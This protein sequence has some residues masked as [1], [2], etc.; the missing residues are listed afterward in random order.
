MAKRRI[1]MLLVLAMLLVMMA[2]QV[3]MGAGDE[4][5]IP[6]VFRKLLD[7]QIFDGQPVV[8]WSGSG[9]GELETV[10]DTLPI[11]TEVIYKGKPTL[12]LNLKEDLQSGWWIS[13]VTVRG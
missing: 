11:D 1:S 10:N 8:G 2:P 6:E 9:M 13:L 7:I 3:A 5:V 4:N 12:R